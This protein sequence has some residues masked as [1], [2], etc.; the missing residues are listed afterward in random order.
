MYAV[1][2]R[3]ILSEKNSCLLIHQ[4]SIQEKISGVLWTKLPRGIWSRRQ[5]ETEKAT[6]PG[7]MEKCA[8]DDFAKDGP[9]NPATPWT[10]WTGAGLESDIFFSSEK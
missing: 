2:K 6:A 3:Q 9:V 10:P 7:V 1:K 8:F 5:W 4:T